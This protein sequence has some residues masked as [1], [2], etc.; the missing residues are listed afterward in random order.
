MNKEIDQQDLV[1]FSKLSRSLWVDLN[2]C[3]KGSSEALAVA[4]GGTVSCEGLSRREMKTGL[5]DV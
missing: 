3:E 1:L 4:G 5:K 2:D